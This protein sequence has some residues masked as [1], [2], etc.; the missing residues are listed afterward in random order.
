MSASENISIKSVFN[1]L[2]WL[3]VA[4]IVCLTVITYA[5]AIS[6]SLIPT[7]LAVACPIIASVFAFLFYRL[8]VM[9][10][11]QIEQKELVAEEVL[12]DEIDVTLEEERKPSP[13]VITV[14]DTNGMTTTMHT[15]TLQSPLKNNFL[16]PPLPK[17]SSRLP[18]VMSPFSTQSVLSLQQKPRLM[19][20]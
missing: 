18:P 6:L 3:L 12:E 4:V 14:R 15:V 1:C 10:K 2:F 20:T 8:V 11:L 17:T 9:D 16:M 19:I 7:K 13:P 5:F